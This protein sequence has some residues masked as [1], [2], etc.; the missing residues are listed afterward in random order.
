MPTSVRLIPRR[1]GAEEGSRQPESRASSAAGLQR[2]FGSTKDKLPG[3]K[4]SR[5]KKHPGEDYPPHVWER[6]DVRYVP[7][8]A[9]SRP[10]LLAACSSASYGIKQVDLASAVTTGTAAAQRLVF[11]RSRTYADAR[12]P[13]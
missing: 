11:A 9:D 2:W 8:A 10:H 12:Q 1:E 5:L 13:E 7:I 4:T 3:G 6:R